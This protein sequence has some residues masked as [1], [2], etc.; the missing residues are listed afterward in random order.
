MILFATKFI[1]EF[2]F[3]KL[4]RREK[5]NNTKNVKKM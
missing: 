2:L 3:L 1:Y 4:E 5:N